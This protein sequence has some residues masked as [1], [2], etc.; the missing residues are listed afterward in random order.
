VGYKEDEAQEIGFLCL[1]TL[2][3]GITRSAMKTHIIHIVVGTLL[4]ILCAAAAAFI[5]PLWQ[6]VSGRDFRPQSATMALLILVLASLLRAWR[7]WPLIEFIGALVCAELF[8]LCVI[9]HFSGF[10]WLELFDSFNLSWLDTM[11]V[12]IAVPWLVGLLIGSVL[13]RVRQ[14]DTHDHAA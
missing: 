14:R 9:A 13:L 7:R 12:F 3:G 11:S 2:L 5:P 8:T 1:N 6:G 10:T 4:M